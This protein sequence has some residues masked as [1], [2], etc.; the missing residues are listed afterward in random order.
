MY[1]N[2]IYL[3][4]FGGW[5]ITSCIFGFNATMVTTK[6]VLVKGWTSLL[7]QQSLKRIIIWHHMS[8]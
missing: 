1:I 6:L 7:V 2:F 3:F 4:I 5:G 8:Q